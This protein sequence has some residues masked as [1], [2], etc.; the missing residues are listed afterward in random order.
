MRMSMEWPLNMGYKRLWSQ[1]MR[2]DGLRRRIIALDN[3]VHMDF[4]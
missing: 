4:Q 3:N 1:N 2:V